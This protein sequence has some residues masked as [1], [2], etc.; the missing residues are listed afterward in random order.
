MIRWKV[1]NVAFGRSDCR[2]LIA[3][4]DNSHFWFYVPAQLTTSSFQNIIRELAECYHARE[5]ELKYLYEGGVPCEKCLVEVL[6]L[7]GRY[8][9]RNELPVLSG[10][11]QFITY[12]ES[13]IFER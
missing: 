3:K 8:V 11:R 13:Y 9:F 5:V 4:L 10:R 7:D 6:K 1:N 12:T 2:S